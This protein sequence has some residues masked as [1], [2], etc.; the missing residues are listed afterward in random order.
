MRRANGPNS[1]ADPVETLVALPR[2]LR[3]TALSRLV[4]VNP[5]AYVYALQSL[6]Q[7][8]GRFDGSL[9]GILNAGTIRAINAACRDTPGFGCG[10]PLTAATAAHLSAAL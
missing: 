8:A 6:L 4:T 1:F 2:D 9:S 5:N 10:N 3:N 7:R